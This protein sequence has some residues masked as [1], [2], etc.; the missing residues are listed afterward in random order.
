MTYTRHRPDNGN[1]RG[2][3]VNVVDMVPMCRTVLGIMRCELED[4]SDMSSDMS[5]MSR[6]RGI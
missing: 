2:G 3:G 5:R 1:T 6:I 4:S